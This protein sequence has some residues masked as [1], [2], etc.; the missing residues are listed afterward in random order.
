MSGG[1]LPVKH[2]FYE[3]T[4]QSLLATSARLRLA[5]I[6]RLRAVPYDGSWT[7]VH[8]AVGHRSRSP[9]KVGAELS[10]ATTAYW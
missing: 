7:Q 6:D 9:K 5:L 8:H 2:P 1:R 3:S 4:C 10:Q